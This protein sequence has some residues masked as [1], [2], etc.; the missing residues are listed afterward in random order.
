MGEGLISKTRHIANVDAVVCKLFWATV[1]L[2]FILEISRV[3]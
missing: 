3:L 1:I 2:I